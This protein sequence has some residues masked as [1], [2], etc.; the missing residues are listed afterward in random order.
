MSPIRVVVGEDSYL[1]REGIVRVLDG[2]ED[3]EVLEACAD[4][5]SLREAVA[6]LRPDVVLT[7]IRMPPTGTDEGIRL[8]LELRASHPK[9]GVVVLSQFV[10]PR[11]ALALFRGGSDGRAYILTERIRDRGE[12]AHALRLVASGGSLVDPVI[13]EKL[14]EDGSRPPLSRLESL[15]PR[16]LEILGIIASGASNGAIADE[17]RITK[18]AVERHIN[19][20]FA[21]LELPGPASEV[22]PRVSATLLYLASNGH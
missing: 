8:A 7:D 22:S 6:R 1:T 11:Y 18:R 21:K 2:I 3:V 10:D 12:I 4:L 14:L 16:E 17:L 13:V 19:G 15:T 5:D 20:I 9:I